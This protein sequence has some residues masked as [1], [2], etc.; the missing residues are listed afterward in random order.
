E[1]AAAAR[2]HRQP[3]WFFGRAEALAT[4]VLG[5]V[6]AGGRPGDDSGG[7]RVPGAPSHALHR[8]FAAHLRAQQPDGAAGAG[9]GGARRGARG[10]GAVVGLAAAADQAGVAA[11]PGRV[12]ALHPRGHHGA[13]AVS[14]GPERQLPRGPPPRRLGAPHAALPPGQQPLRRLSPGAAA[15]RR[16]GDAAPRR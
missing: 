7:S 12:H 16:A 5:P 14:P 2:A 6:P 15:G 8:P 11:H 10:G 9:G 4:P 3:A 13:A 1:P